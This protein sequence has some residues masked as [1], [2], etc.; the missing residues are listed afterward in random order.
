MLFK[1]FFQNYR[2]LTYPE[3]LTLRISYGLKFFVVLTIIFSIFEYNIFLTACAITMLIFSAL[4]AIIEKQF[5]IIL[6]VEVEL[7]YTIFIFLHFILGEAANLYNRIWFYDLILHF[8]SGI[9]VGLVG[10]I[11]I[12]FFM[13]TNRLRANPLMAVVFSISFSLAAG[14]F[15][16]IIEFLI[17]MTFGFNMQKVETGIVDTMSD[18]IVDLLGA[19]IVGFWV[20]RYLKKNEDGLIK[21]TVKRFIQYNI[22]R[23]ERKLQKKT[24]IN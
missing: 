20:Y 7:V 8:S 4:P 11:I 6:P 21:I 5:R 16:E 13:H 19:C 15:W 23:K 12:Y 1:N 17:D 9:L 10:F 14:A 3:I 18:L 24:N 2:Q 22:R